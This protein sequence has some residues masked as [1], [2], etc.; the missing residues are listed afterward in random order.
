MVMMRTVLFLVVLALMLGG[1]GG[2]SSNSSSSNTKL[3]PTPQNSGADQ[4]QKDKPRFPK[5]PPK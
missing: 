5:P 4:Q 1:L 2:C 3:A